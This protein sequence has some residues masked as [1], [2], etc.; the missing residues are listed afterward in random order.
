MLA[1]LFY[2]VNRQRAVYS[3]LIEKA[4]VNVN[5]IFVQLLVDPE[6]AESHIHLVKHEEWSQIF[7]MAQC[8]HL[9]ALL[10]HGIKQ[11]DIDLPVELRENLRQLLRK[12]TMDTLRKRAELL[13]VLRKL[14]DLGIR[15]ILLKGAV[16]AN[17]VYPSYF[18]RSMG[19]IDLWIQREKMVQAKEA[20]ETIGYIYV[21]TEHRPHAMQ[22]L[23]DGE[24]QMRGQ[25]SITGLVELHYGPFG[26]EWTR[27][28]MAHIDRSAI[29][30]RLLSHFIDAQPIYSLSLEDALIQLALHVGIHHQMAANGLRS[31]IDI[32]FLSRMGIDWQ[33]V[34]QRCQEWRVYSAVSF[35]ID[36]WNQLFAT[37]QSI[38]AAAAMPFHRHRLMSFF[39]K[40]ADIV[41]GHKLAE[42]RLRMLYQLF[43]VDRV[44]DAWKLIAHTI[45]PDQEWLNARYNAA[46]ARTRLQHLQRVVAGKL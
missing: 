44:P 42:S 13:N 43:L 30:D 22:V 12:T 26:G 15:P 37:E 39:V 5:Q 40:P 19:D 3:S 46:D 35:V 7:Q 23:G 2:Y 6:K 28:V 38:Q 29:E 16:L 33:I 41:D 18:H 1:V 24:M 36:L 25:T 14:N 34:S 17:W 27:I 9:I 20:L 21:E 32:E 4:E 8:T 11:T 45:W 31:L 10:H